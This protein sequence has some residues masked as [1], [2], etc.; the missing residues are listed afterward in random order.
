MSRRLFVL[1]VVLLALGCSRAENKADSIVI[2]VDSPQSELLPPDSLAT[3][4][5]ATGG[6]RIAGSLPRRSSGSAA[7]RPPER[8]DRGTTPSGGSARR[9]P[10][11]DSAPTSTQRGD[12]SVTSSSAPDTARGIVAVVGTSFESKV[13]LRGPEGRRPI[14]LIGPQAR[15]IGQLSGADVWVSGNR[16][17]YGQIRVSR[18]V[19][20]GV[21]GN[22]ALDGTLIARGDRL[23][24][25][26][27]DGQQHAIANP[28]AA[29]REHVGARVWVSGPVDRAMIA[30][31]VIEERR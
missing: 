10:P 23:L 24:V 31:G 26:T 6:A 30:F 13:V 17:P 7:A 11:A 25:V 3:G 1:P 9:Q 28:P 19:V 15:V 16:D 21:D 18:F 20:R 5:R 22:P 8:P 29:L 4:S 14:T 12:S 27:R 2:L